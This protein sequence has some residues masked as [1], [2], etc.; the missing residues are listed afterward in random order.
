MAR[1]RRAG[2]AEAVAL[3]AAS[4][5]RRPP[6]S[7]AIP[8]L[9]GVV[10]VLLGVVAF[11]LRRGRAAQQRQRPR[12]QPATSGSGVKVFGSP[13]I[14]QR[15]ATS[16]SGAARSRTSR[17][18]RSAIGRPRSPRAAPRPAGSALPAWSAGIAGRAAELAAAA[19]PSARA[20]MTGSSTFGRYRL[21]ERLGEGGMAELYTAVLHGAEGFRRVLR[22]QAAAPAGRAQPRRGRAVHRRGEAAD[23]RWCTRTSFPCS[24]SARSATSTSSRRSTSSGAISERLLQPPHG[25]VGRP[26]DRAADPVHRARGAGGAG[27][28]AQPD[29]R[30]RA[31]PSAS[32]TATS[33]RATS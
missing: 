1:A 27:V 24:T 11:L 5:P 18:R 26:L 19:V 28:R 17:P 15:A 4:D 2:R 31:V 23:R 8:V 6:A 33:R 29:R 21:L 16:A 13:R 3:G 10:A 7:D 30:R 25:E 9:L 22:R 20:S 14:D 12:R 32:S